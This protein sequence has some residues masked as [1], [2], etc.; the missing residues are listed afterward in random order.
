MKVIF[1]SLVETKIQKL[2]G[3]ISN[4][5]RLHQ[6]LS[7]SPRWPWVG[8][9]GQIHQSTLTGRS[10][11]HQ[12]FALN[13]VS[14]DLLIFLFFADF[15]SLIIFHPL[16]NNPSSPYSP[17]INNRQGATKKRYQSHIILVM[18]MYN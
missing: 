13:W 1:I 14:N 5:S 17:L 6:T 11:L 2:D 16:P 3:F 4:S 12:T 8:S 10:P 7:F 15:P 9:S 18:L